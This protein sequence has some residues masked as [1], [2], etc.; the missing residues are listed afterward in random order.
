MVIFYNAQLLCQ[1]YGHFLSKDK[2]KA[3]M[4]AQMS[5]VAWRHFSFLGQYEFCNEDKGINIH[6]VMKILFEIAENDISHPSE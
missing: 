1:L 5:P 3:K 2:Q 4:L 6:N